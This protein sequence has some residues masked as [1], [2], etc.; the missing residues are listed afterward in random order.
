MVMDVVLQR[1]SWAGD[2]TGVGQYLASARQWSGQLLAAA[3]VALAGFLLAGL[4]GLLLR[5]LLRLARF[6]EAARRLLAAEG[7]SRF[8]ATRLVVAVVQVVV[9][10]FAGVVAF[11]VM[12]LKLASSVG[13]RLGEVV[14]RIIASAFLLALGSLLALALGATVRR[15]LDRA[16]VRPARLQGQLITLTLTGFSVLL[17]LD[18]LGFA[19]QFVMTLGVIAAATAGLALALAFGLGCR[20][21]ARDFLVEY[22]RAL[23]D[24]EP[25]V[26]R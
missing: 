26:P 18:Q 20:D 8:E 7:A 2:S 25:R 4:V 14:P 24:T 16:G 5:A 9:L 17:A 15:L 6:D 23:D 12:G 10:L 22:L 21:L 11:E 1:P 19:A 13:A 3:A